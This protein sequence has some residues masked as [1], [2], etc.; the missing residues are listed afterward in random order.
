MFS[1]LDS[2][3]FQ[4][5]RIWVFY[6]GKKI[7]ANF[8]IKVV[9]KN[10]YRKFKARPTTNNWLD[11]VDQFKNTLWYY[12]MIEEKIKLGINLYPS[13]F[14][15]IK[16]NISKSFSVLTYSDGHQVPKEAFF[17]PEKIL[18]EHYRVRFDSSLFRLTSRKVFQKE[19]FF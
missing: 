9:D 13:D 8:S 12:P 5:T 18:L 6:K 1:S 4:K 2:P 7:A 16:K 14:D 11:V 17:K 15:Y 3:H 19:L 10:L